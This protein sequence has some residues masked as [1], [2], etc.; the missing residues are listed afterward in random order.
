M[1][2]RKQMFAL[3]G[4]V[5]MLLVLAALVVLRPLFPHRSAVDT[6]RWFIWSRSYKSNV[7]AQPDFANGELKH[8][9]WD[10]WGW[11]GQDTTVYLVFDPTDSLS[12]GAREHRSGKLKGIPC[13]V[14]AVDRMEKN[15]YVVRFYTNEWWG[16][17]NALDCTG[18][19]G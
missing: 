19:R 6:A 9:E 11:A 16:R 15:W 18:S 1:S 5:V 3:V 4:F 2:L 13:E 8:S 12:A 14:Y 10:G 7:L 17:R